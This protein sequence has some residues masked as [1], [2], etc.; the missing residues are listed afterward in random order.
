[1][2]RYSP[3]TQRLQSAQLKNN[4]WY[5]QVDEI[6]SGF[7]ML[8]KIANQ[9]HTLLDILLASVEV[10]A[11]RDCNVQE[12]ME[13][14]KTIGADKVMALYKSKR[15]LR[16][17][18]QHPRL[19]KV[20]NYIYIMDENERTYMGS[21][22]QGMV[23][24]IADYL[25]WC[26]NSKEQLSPLLVQHLCKNYV[27]YGNGGAQHILNDI[28]NGTFKPGKTIKAYVPPVQPKIILA[29]QQVVQ[30]NPKRHLT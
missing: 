3:E 10:L 8:N 2:I 9:S 15:K 25:Q 1:M 26:R 18:D 30:P 29:G 21:S 19:H 13:M 11:E 12:R 23:L 27:E 6:A 24:V 17:M 14:L 28:K 7:G 5:D 20:V 16:K 4:R 22:I